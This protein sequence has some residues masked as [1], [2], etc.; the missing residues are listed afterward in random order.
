MNAPEP[1]EVPAEEL[2]AAANCSPNQHWKTCSLCNYD[3]HDCPGCG[4]P[5]GHVND[6]QREVC[7]E[8]SNRLAADELAAGLR[9]ALR[10]MARRCAGIRR[11]TRDSLSM[12]RA[13]EFE[14]ESYREATIARVR[15]ERDE[16][17]RAGA[18]DERWWA[19]W[20]EFVDNADALRAERDRLRAFLLEA[21]STLPAYGFADNDLGDPWLRWVERVAAYLTETH[22]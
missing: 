7:A 4:A 13:A 17:I 22:R 16:L 1:V 14:T 12:R 10:S 9:A 5:T 20:R 11:E 8:C 15:E 18:R 2:A 3:T 21:T 19:E 6:N